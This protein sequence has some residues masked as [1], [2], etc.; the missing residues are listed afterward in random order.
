MYFPTS[1]ISLALLVASCDSS[2]SDNRHLR[3]N[4]TSEAKHSFRDLAYASNDMPLYDDKGHQSTGPHSPA[5]PSTS[6]FNIALVNM[7]E[8]TSYDHLFKRA[9]TKWEQIVIGDLPDMPQRSYSAHDWFG[10]EWEETVNV[11]IDDVLIGYSTEN[12]DGLGGVLGFAGPIYSRRSDDSVT[13]VSGV[14]KFDGVDF[15]R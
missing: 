2:D 9:A 1:L 7:G 10:N 5:S 12:I 15:S 8:D 3:R 11:D 6:K 14:M 13:A 4:P